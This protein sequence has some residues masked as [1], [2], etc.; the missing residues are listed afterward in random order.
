MTLSRERPDTC[1]RRHRRHGRHSARKSKK[2]R[3]RA[4]F[5]STG[6]FVACPASVARRTDDPAGGKC[7]KCSPFSALSAL[8]AVPHLPHVAVP[9]SMRLLVEVIADAIKEDGESI[10]PVP[11]EPFVKA[12]PESAIRARYYAGIAETAKEGEDP[13]TLAARQ[14]K[15]FNRAIKG[16]ID[17]K[18]AK[19]A[20]WFGERWIW[21]P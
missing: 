16:T 10:T 14:R 9:A 8:S 18:I 5:P 17:R 7:G 1:L 6:S 4:L 20:N 13:K 19:A 11:D 12:G 3:Q 15:S 2:P 21:L